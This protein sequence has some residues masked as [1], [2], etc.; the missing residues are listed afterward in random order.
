V[1]QV[2]T[3][4]VETNLSFSVFNR[5]SGEFSFLNTKASLISISRVCLSQNTPTKNSSFPSSTEI[6]K[7]GESLHVKSFS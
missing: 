2:R 1:T 4:S 7:E 3:H 6:A 5:L